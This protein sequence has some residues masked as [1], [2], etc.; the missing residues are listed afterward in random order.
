M[1]FV[2]VHPGYK[3]TVQSGTQRAV[4]HPSG[5]TEFYPNDDAFTAEFKVQ[6][7]SVRE[8]TAATEQLL[9]GPRGRYVFGSHPS[10]D[11]GNISPEAAIE[12]GYT[13][14]AHDGYDPYQ[15]LSSF[16]TRDEAQCPERWRE[17]TEEFLVNHYERE[18][19]YVRV[20]DYN[21]TPPWPTF[22]V[23]GKVEVAPL[24]R[25]AGQAGLLEAALEFELGQS[26]RAPLVAALET[27]IAELHAKQEEEAALTA[28]V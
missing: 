22:P 23:A 18:R 9:G 12:M 16:D 26:N 4:T 14:T 20:D 27:A 25:F 15:Q 7:L 11:E 21:L 3:I 13:G 8:I 24:V 10:R 6:A 19:A 1:K 2:S 28:R 5:V 17:Q